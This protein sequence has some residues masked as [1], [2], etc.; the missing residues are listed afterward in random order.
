MTDN[1][2]HDKAKTN[3]EV[4]G[5]HE[6]FVSCNHIMTKGRDGEKGNWCVDCGIKVYDVETR[7]CEDCKHFF[8]R[9][10]NYSGCKKHLM[11]VTPDMY[12]TFKIEDGTCWTCS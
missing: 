5:P 6:R 9:P 8:S 12:V 10:M 7:K 2:E 1:T 4:A 3:D 11:A